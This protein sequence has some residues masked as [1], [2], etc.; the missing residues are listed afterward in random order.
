[1]NQREQVAA[2]IICSRW[3]L[4]RGFFCPEDGG[5]AFFRFISQDLHGATSQKTAFFKKLVHDKK[6]DFVKKVQEPGMKRAEKCFL[7]LVISYSSL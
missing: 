2:V 4:A 6:M 5:D 1:M 3:F 7:I